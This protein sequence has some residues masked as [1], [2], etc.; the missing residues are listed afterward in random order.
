MASKGSFP[1]NR[2]SGWNVD[3]DYSCNH[4]GFGAAPLWI[5]QQCLSLNLNIVCVELRIELL[6]NGEMA[7]TELTFT[8]SFFLFACFTTFTFIM[9]RAAFLSPVY[10]ITL[11]ILRVWPW[12]SLLCVILLILW[13][14]VC[15]GLCKSC[16]CCAVQ[17]LLYYWCEYREMH[18]Y[19]SVTAKADCVFWLDLLCL[20]NNGLGLCDTTDHLNMRLFPSS[21]THN[22]CY[23]CIPDIKKRKGFWSV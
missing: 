9:Y 6:L 5:H 23:W 13:H 11:W 19:Q 2:P 7:D 3:K 8:S 14:I 10:L 22:W 18:Q 4:L 16:S 21:I 17:K 12:Q 20:F 15:F 1:F